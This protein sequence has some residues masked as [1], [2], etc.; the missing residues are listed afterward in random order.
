MEDYASPLNR[1]ARGRVFADHWRRPTEYTPKRAPLF[2]N[3][4]LADVMPLGKTIGPNLGVTAETLQDLKFSSLVP[5]HEAPKNEPGPYHGPHMPVDKAAWEE[6]RAS[7]VRVEREW[8]AS[9]QDACDDE[10]SHTT[11]LRLR[12]I[13]FA[14]NLTQ[15]RRGT[16]GNG[17]AI[18][19]GRRVLNSSLHDEA[20]LHGQGLRSRLG[21]V[22][23]REQIRL[24]LIG[25]AK[26]EKVVITV[27]ADNGKVDTISYAPGMCPAGL[28]DVLTRD[29]V[30][31]TGRW[32]RDIQLRNEENKR[33][34]REIWTDHYQ[35]EG[36]QVGLT[37]SQ[38]LGIFWGGV[39]LGLGLSATLPRQA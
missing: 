38:R 30:A 23:P 13:A 6:E 3:P 32:A 28:L 24:R 7:K 10:T 29:A 19:G 18:L 34:Y 1:A 31:I 2:H 33:Y 25:T 39:K 8:N 21:Q 20:R 16:R 14:D 15:T 26:R 5:L 36:N 35:S 22:L 17:I 37:L 27:V 12:D 4:R 11:Q 9:V